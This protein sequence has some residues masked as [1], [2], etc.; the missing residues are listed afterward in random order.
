VFAY[1]SLGGLV[2]KH[3]SRLELDWLGV[4]YPT[5][6]QDGEA[7]A[8]ETQKVKAAVEE[9]APDE[10]AFALRLL[11]LGG[12]WWPS[13]QFFKHHNGRNFPYGHH[14]PSNLDIG[15][16]PTGE[17]LVLN[18]W[19]GNS[20]YL[21]SP[22]IPGQRPDVPAMTP[23][24]WSRLALCRTMEERCDVLR[25]FG[26]VEYTSAEECPD[27][28]ESIAHGIVTG[29]RYEELMNKMDDRDYVDAWMN[30]W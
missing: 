23:N 18:T 1:P 4:T 25:D 12:R 28:P 17:V 14:F 29:R 7:H 13:E 10:D 8:N 15:Y 16:R 6:S 11:Q 5:A 21:E 3:V 26:A 30:S 19:A 2:K 22:E 20:P 9:N 27:V 24:D